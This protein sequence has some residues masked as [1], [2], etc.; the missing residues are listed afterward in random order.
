[1]SGIPRHRQAHA[2]RS[3]PFPIFGMCNLHR[4]R[5]RPTVCVP[6]PV[7]VQLFHAWAKGG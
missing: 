6:R 5:P 3:L 1:M 4:Q 2:A 7:G